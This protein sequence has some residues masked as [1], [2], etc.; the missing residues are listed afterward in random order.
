MKE[1]SQW[2]STKQYVFILLLCITHIPPLGTLRITVFVLECHH[3]IQ[4]HEWWREYS[5]CSTHV[6]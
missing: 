6:H 4:S 5:G 1:H 3:R 2:T